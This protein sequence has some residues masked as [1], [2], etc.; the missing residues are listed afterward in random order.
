MGA[1]IRTASVFVVLGLIMCSIGG[2]VDLVF[3]YSYVFLIAMLVMTVLLSV[4]TVWSSKSMALRAN[5]AYIITRE[6]EPRLYGIVEKVAARA[7]LPMPEVGIS[8]YSMPNAFA[9]GRSPRDAAVVATRGILGV[10]DDDELEGV[11]G[12]EMSTSRTATSW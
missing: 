3:G 4:I 11:I 9:T 7:G 12:H 1:I 10:L 5:K 6:E 2:L 8:E